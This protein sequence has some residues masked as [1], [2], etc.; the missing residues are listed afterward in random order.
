[1]LVH[2]LAN[3]YFRHSRTNICVHRHRLDGSSSS[4]HSHLVP[5]KE[6]G[7]EDMFEKA[8]TQ[9]NMSPLLRRKLSKGTSE[10]KC[11]TLSAAHLMC[12]RKRSCLS[13][14]QS[15]C[16]C[17]RTQITSTDRWM[18]WSALSWTQCW[19]SQTHLRHDAA[20]HRASPHCLS[21]YWSA[22]TSVSPAMNP[23]RCQIITLYLC[24]K[25]QWLNLVARWGRG[26]C[27]P[28]I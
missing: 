21:R 2:M 10:S 1:M 15:I 12:Q 9:T 13:T 11:L 14:A 3:V 16:I 8:N 27:Q 7:G 28:T 20:D 24:Q 22:Y 6:Q 19:A 17:I 26:D 18:H 25:A 4:V 23:W 5:T